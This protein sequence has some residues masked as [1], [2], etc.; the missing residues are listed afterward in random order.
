V[1]APGTDEDGMAV[2]VAEIEWPVGLGPIA[3]AIPTDMF[4]PM[5]DR[6][7]LAIT[8]AEVSQRLTGSAPVGARLCMPSA[9]WP[10]MRTH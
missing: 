4:V 9:A 5:T 7:V 6:I 8:E 2:L 3:V 10:N 1:L